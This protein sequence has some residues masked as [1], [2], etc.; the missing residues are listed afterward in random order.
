M[1]EQVTTLKKSVKLVEVNPEIEETPVD[2]RDNGDSESLSTRI[3][4]GLAG[5]P[6]SKQKMAQKD[7]CRTC[8]NL[9]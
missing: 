2:N 9:T 6:L 8:L 7:T 4:T 5:R 1:K 3:T